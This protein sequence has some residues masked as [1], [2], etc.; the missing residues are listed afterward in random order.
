[1]VG[2]R[3]LRALW[4]VPLIGLLA[5]TW[6]PSVAQ[7]GWSAGIKATLPDGAGSDPEAGLNAVSCAS[8]GNCAATGSYSDRSGNTRQLLVTQV[9]GNWGPGVQAP[10]DGAVNDFDSSSVSCA[11]AGSCTAVVNSGRSLVTETAGVWGGLVVPGPPP[12]ASA[13]PGVVD[14]FTSVSCPSPGNCTAVGVYVDNSNQQQAMMVNETS[15]AW[16]T[17]VK[18]IPPSDIPSHGFVSLT[19]VS[20]VSPSNCSATGSYGD[21]GNPHSN[22]RGLLLTETGG[23]WRQGVRPP[24]T[25]SAGSVD[26]NSVSCASPSNCAAVGSTG[27]GEEPGFGLLLTLNGST[28]S[29]MT[30]PDVPGASSGGGPPGG[31][32]PDSVS[33]PAA[34]T[35]VAV[36]EDLAWAETSGTWTAPTSIPLPQGATEGGLDAVSC[37]SPLNCAAIGSYVDGS[38]HTQGLLVT[39][40]SGKWGNPTTATL[41]ADAGADPNVSLSSVFCL[42]SG[43]CAAVGTYTDTAGHTQGLLLTGTGPGATGGGTLGTGRPSLL[44]SAPSRGKVGQRIAAS[45]LS[46]TLV[47]GLKPVGTITFKVFG[48]QPSPPS[49]CSGGGTVVGTAS[50]YDYGVYQSSRGFT[51]TRAGTYWWYARYGGDSHNRPAASRCGAGMRKMVVSARHNAV[52]TPVQLL[53]SPRFA[54][55]RLSFNL[56]CSG[57]S[58]G[59][60]HTVSVMTS[61]NVAVGRVRTTIADMSIARV[62][63]TLNAQG[64]SLLRRQHTISA[65]LSVKSGGHV[66]VK[67]KLTLSS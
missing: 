52:S 21:A 40:A 55:N 46:G 38:G 60:C 59:S 8:P 51:P 48:P 31:P 54:G 7:A 2:H 58:G 27:G 13:G 17:A 9:S 57:L 10:P 30:A 44:L 14:F 63:L 5:M 49:N 29:G 47:P 61:S 15:G 11:P 43:D 25:S 67:R 4:L 50:A 62:T 56:G 16:G 36:G 6:Q 64:R 1:M 20:C 35:C 34:G 19:R 42:P 53:G 3:N 12:D 23:N 26:I 22:G 66:V 39:E 28:W 45:A 37:V 32:V 33:C 24:G 18:A 65:T 41:P